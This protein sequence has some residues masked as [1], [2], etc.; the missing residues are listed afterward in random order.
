[1]RPKGSKR[2]YAGGGPGGEEL[3]LGGEVACW[4]RVCHLAHHDSILSE[5]VLVA[6]QNA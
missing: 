5:N 6:T 1:M 3:G 2:V 4:I